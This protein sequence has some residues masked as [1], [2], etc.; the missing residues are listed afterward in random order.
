MLSVTAYLFFLEEKSSRLTSRN[1][2]TLSLPSSLGLLHSNE[3]GEPYGDRT[4]FMAGGYKNQDWPVKCFNGHKNWVLGWYKDRQL[5]LN[6]VTD[7][8]KLIRL[9][10]FV[11][12]QKATKDEPVLVNIMDRLFLQYNR[13]KD[14][15]RE[16]EEKQNK[17]TI[18]EATNVGSDNRAG[19]GFGERF[20]YQNF[21]GK[22]GTLIIEV[23]DI[24][25]GG[26]DKHRADA[27]LVS[28]GMGVV[29]CARDRNPR[30]ASRPTPPAQAPQTGPPTITV[31]TSTPTTSPP[32]T[33]N[34]TTGTPTSLEPTTA[35]PTTMSPTTVAPTTPEPTTFP[36]EAPTDTGDNC[37]SLGVLCPPLASVITNIPTAVSTTNRDCN[38]GSGVLCLEKPNDSAAS[39]SPTSFLGDKQ[40]V[41]VDCG[42]GSGMPCDKKATRS[43]P[44]LP[45]VSPETAIS[46]P[47]NASDHS[48]S[49]IPSTSAP[50]ALVKSKVDC[51]AEHA[52]GIPCNDSTR[53]FRIP[54]R[55][56]ESKPPIT[57]NDCDELG[58][59][60]SEGRSSTGTPA[61]PMTHPSAAPKTLP[62]RITFDDARLPADK[63]PSTPAPALV[64]D[65]HSSST[66]ESSSANGREIDNDCDG[67][68]VICANKSIPTTNLPKPRND[69]TPTDAPA[70]P[71][72]PPPENAADKMPPITKRLCRL[73]GFRCRGGKITPPLPTA[74]NTSNAERNVDCDGSGVLCDTTSS[75]NTLDQT[76]EKPPLKKN[77]AVGAP[78][79]HVAP[80][81]TSKL[82]LLFGFTCRD[83]RP[84]T[85]PSTS[86]LYPDGDQSDQSGSTPSP[87]A[88]PSDNSDNC[89]TSGILCGSEAPTSSATQTNSPGS[90]GSN[91]STTATNS[92]TFNTTYKDCDRFG[93]PCP[94][95]TEG[96]EPPGPPPPPGG[97]AH[98]END[99]RP[100]GVG[101]EALAG[102]A[103]DRCDEF[104]IRCDGTTET[105]RTPVNESN[106]SLSVTK[107][108]GR[109]ENGFPVKDGS[110]GKKLDGPQPSLP[111]A[112]SLDRVFDGAEYAVDIDDEIASST[113]SK[114]HTAD[115]LW[116]PAPTATPR[117][118]IEGGYKSTR[119][120]SPYLGPNE[121]VASPNSAPAQAPN[122]HHTISDPG[123]TART[124]ESI[125]YLR[126]GPDR[127][128]VAFEGIFDND[129]DPS[130]S[131]SGSYSDGESV[132][133]SSSLPPP[134]FVDPRPAVEVVLLREGDGG[135][136]RSLSTSIPEPPRLQ[137]PTRPG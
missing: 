92:L 90:S 38:G 83:R 14:F 2:S 63:P 120:Y 45:A 89:V 130:S 85:S 66:P 40:D 133:S 36:T 15:N 35:T 93:I 78:P 79:P 95:R 119:I 60:C 127:G 32:A 46:V 24:A 67:L 70:S 137:W 7:S 5:E 41:K 52:K 94:G 22:G 37:G 123:K 108:D 96:K 59:L 88:R 50:P 53:T 106:D 76:K 109:V 61:M 16:T 1:V 65:T 62:S 3:N 110:S 47:S 77:R 13:A 132:L 11:D 64:N 57:H 91:S 122:D 44:T 51:D 56:K 55:S 23:C 69:V 6:P 82:C 104:G 31:T 10:A 111:P 74:V 86:E 136:G 71:S 134:G 17:V 28:V 84:A 118:D 97:P 48:S 101:D 18:T 117:V 81:I 29:L 135:K 107:N 33:P 25:M 98:D 42:G 121:P 87:K 129:A 68:R 114:K 126:L 102:N 128:G 39:V 21:D 72:S 49:T 125:T 112:F 115:P 19:L 105:P 99:D 8:V 131:T 116:L 75:N 80:P 124:R 26:D 43:E 58:V 103:R 20:E 100:S 73:F 30:Y 113:D 27:I 54:G 4:G 34:P 12:Y 9:A